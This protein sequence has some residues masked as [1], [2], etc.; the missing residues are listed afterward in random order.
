MH[1]QTAVDFNRL[2]HFRVRVLHISER[3]NPAKNTRNAKK[4]AGVITLKMRVIGVA[5]L[6]ALWTVI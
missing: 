6:V 2:V 1:Q 4:T 3:E 5:Q